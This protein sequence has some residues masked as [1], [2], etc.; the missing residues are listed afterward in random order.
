MLPEPHR[1]GVLPHADPAVVV[2]R[3]TGIR[4]ERRAPAAPGHRPSGNVYA[5]SI[6]MRV[7]RR[8][9]TDEPVSEVQDVRDLIAREKED[10]ICPFSVIA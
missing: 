1:R 3:H 7:F 5:C 10:A 9:P 4:L 2:A 8:T 6:S